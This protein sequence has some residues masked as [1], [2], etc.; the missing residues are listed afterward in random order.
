MSPMR[1]DH[2]RSHVYCVMGDGEQDEGQLGS[3]DVLQLR[4]SCTTLTVIIDWRN[5][6]D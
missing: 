3:G 5:I 6:S 1:M 2:K 4:K